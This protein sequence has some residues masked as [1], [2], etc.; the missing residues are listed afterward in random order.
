MEWEEEAEEEEEEEEMMDMV[1][2][3]A[4]GWAGLPGAAEPSLPRG[5]S[6][7]EGVDTARGGL[8]GKT[9]LLAALGIPRARLPGGGELGGEAGSGGQP[10]ALSVAAGPGGRHRG[11]ADRPARALATGMPERKRFVGWGRRC[12]PRTMGGRLFPASVDLV[13]EQAGPSNWA[14]SCS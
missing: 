2:V 13:G 1:E 12:A 7:G 14:T 9:S 5:A 8:G 6:G 3:L 11:V 4:S 10:C